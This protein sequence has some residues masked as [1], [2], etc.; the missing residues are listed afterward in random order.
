MGL[1]ENLHPAPPRFESVEAFLAWA[2]IQAER[3]EL[4]DGTARMMTG[5][6]ANHARISGNTLAVLL[7]R[8]AG[9]RC[10]AFGSDLAIILGPR[11]AVYP[12][13]SVSCEPIEE[14]GLT[15]PVVIVE[16]LSPSTAAF[17]LG[18]KASAYRKLPSLRHLVL[19]HQDRIG[20]RHYHRDAEGEEFALTELDRIDEPLRLTA[21]DLDLSLAEIYARVTFSG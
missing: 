6:T 12:D 17:D 14:A 15:Q 20:V 18:D 13:V 7:S 8:L 19:V 2:E 9:T 21:I 3:Y 1:A 11:S 16:V 4:V 5:G 10:E